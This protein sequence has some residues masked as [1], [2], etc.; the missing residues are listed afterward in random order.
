MFLGLG[1]GLMWFGVQGNNVSGFGIQ[2]SNYFWSG[3]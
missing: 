1:S 2:T 3:F